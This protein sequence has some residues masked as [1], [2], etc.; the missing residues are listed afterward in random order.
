M[1]AVLCTVCVGVTGHGQESVKWG[2]GSM[3]GED[4]KGWGEGVKAAGAIGAVMLA[5]RRMLASV[6]CRAVSCRVL[7][8]P[9]VSCRVAAVRDILLWMMTVDAPGDGAKNRLEKSF[10][11][12]DMNGRPA[13][14]MD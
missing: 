2:A 13:R 5:R 12:L 10:R 8:C 4:M 11:R 1:P 9:A 6:P 3:R 14:V 7:P